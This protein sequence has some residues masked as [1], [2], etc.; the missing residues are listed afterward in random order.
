MKSRKTGSHR[1]PVF[2]ELPKSVG[3]ATQLEDQCAQGKAQPNEKKGPGAFPVR[4]S[5]GEKLQKDNLDHSPC[6][7]SQGNHQ[8]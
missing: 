6:G 5:F 1:L 2:A 7:Q 4:K 8:Q 3:V